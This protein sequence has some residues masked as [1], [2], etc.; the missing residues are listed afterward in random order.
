M[1]FFLWRS[2]KWVFRKF[3]IIF[4]LKTASKKVVFRATLF[5]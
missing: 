2:E 4:V 1:Q 3:F 5:L